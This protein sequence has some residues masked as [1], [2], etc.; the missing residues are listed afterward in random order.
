MKRKGLIIKRNGTLTTLT[1]TGVYGNSCLTDCA[2]VTDEFQIKQC[3]KIENT[4]PI[5]HERIDR[6]LFEK[7]QLK[8]ADF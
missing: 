4:R 8:L 1:L 3:D 5:K 6:F 7:T 2:V